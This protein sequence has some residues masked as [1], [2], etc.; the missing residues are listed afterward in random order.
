MGLYK[1]I[2]GDI[3]D[4]I[5]GFIRIDDMNLQILGLGLKITITNKYLKVGK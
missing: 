1:K 2:T 5:G 4:G 3:A